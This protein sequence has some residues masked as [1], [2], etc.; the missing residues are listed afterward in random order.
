MCKCNSITSKRLSVSI[1]IG[2]Y[3]YLKPNPNTS[4]YIMKVRKWAVSVKSDR[5]TNPKIF[6]SL[7]LCL[8]CFDSIL[9]NECTAFCRM[10]TALYLMDVQHS[11]E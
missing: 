10:N 1:F 9:S 4:S 6:S 11:I 5:K 7:L 8:Y 2:L 3:Q